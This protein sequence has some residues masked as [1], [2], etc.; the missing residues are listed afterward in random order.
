M[1]TCKVRG[2]PTPG[3][4]LR[5]SEAWQ[6]SR[7][8]FSSFS[9]C[10]AGARV[11]KIPRPRFYI[12]L[13]VNEFADDGADKLSTLQVSTDTCAL[14]T[15]P[16][17]DAQP[18]RT[19]LCSKCVRDHLLEEVGKHQTSI[20]VREACGAK[21]LIEVSVMVIKEPVVRLVLVRNRAR[22]CGDSEH[23]RA[24]LQHRSFSACHSATFRRGSAAG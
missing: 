1:V 14:E 18:G 9:S 11:C 6:Y 13:L 5:R 20:P 19:A 17:L 2:A 7:V 24:Y 23:L 15:Q 12:V 8:V 21:D 16:S 10:I 3:Q 22:L 4:A